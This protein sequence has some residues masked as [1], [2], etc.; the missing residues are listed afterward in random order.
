MLV[1]VCTALHYLELFVKM[2]LMGVTGPTE[3]K[4]LKEERAVELGSELI[5]EVFLYGVAASYIMY[6]YYKSV[7]KEQERDD[8][9][10]MQL[11]KLHERLKALDVEMDNV[12]AKVIALEQTTTGSKPSKRGKS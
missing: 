2:R 3:Y 8:N 7:K 10:D 5:G 12:K 6:E 1:S 11:A 9:Q 4:P